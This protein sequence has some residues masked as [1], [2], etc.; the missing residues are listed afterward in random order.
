MAVKHISF[1]VWD[2]LDSSDAAKSYKPRVHRDYLAR[3]PTQSA[4]GILQ[5]NPPN[6]PNIG[7][8]QKGSEPDEPNTAPKVGIK[9]VRYVTG[10]KRIN[11]VLVILE[12]KNA[13]SAGTLRVIP[14][15]HKSKVESLVRSS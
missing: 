3:L 11:L 8:C 15:S 6:K 4:K 2:Q 13:M 5:T 12:N 7:N 1:L 9:K 14:N 10:S